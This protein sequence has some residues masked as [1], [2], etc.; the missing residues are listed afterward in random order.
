MS[1]LSNMRTGSAG[2][3]LA[4][5]ASSAVTTGMFII[6]MLWHFFAKSVYFEMLTDQYIIT[7]YVV[8]AWACLGFLMCLIAGI[9]FD[10][11]PLIHGSEPFHENAMRQFLVMNFVGQTVIF[12]STFMPTPERIIEFSTVGIAFLSLGV[13]LL[14]GPGRRLFNESSMKSKQ[15]E[16]GL[17]SLIVG[18]VLPLLGAATL[19][20]WM[21]RDTDGMLELGRSILVMFYLLVA[22]VMMISHFNR[23]LNWKIIEPEGLPLRMGAFL[24]LAVLHIL[25]AFLEGREEAGAGLLLTQMKDYT[26]GSTMLV[27]FLICNPLGISKKALL[28]GG[29]AHS[30]P[31]FLALWMLPFASFHAF[32]SISYTDRPGTPGYATFLCTSA[33]LIIWGYAWY[34]H[35]DHLHIN[36]HKRKVNL[37]LLVSFLV[38]FASI[39][40]LYYKNF[41][42]NTDTY[43]EQVMWIS[44][45]IIGALIMA[46]NFVRMTLLTFNTWHRIPM[47]YG[48]YIQ[49]QS[50][51]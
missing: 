3:Y 5:Y 43:I 8:M 29:M 47:F 51:D 7:V 39:Q 50:M 22:L 12:I 38:G 21:F 30:R 23:R 28:N 4:L 34:L 24:L 31:I 41:T 2:S 45:I 49:N 18:M 44:S 37:P 19:T 16:V 6:A 13:F 15:D 35:E 48:R 32:N 26:L 27:A 17:A 9:G 10:I 42:G 36:I 46:F 33:I 40:V 1:T 11:L 14:G 20:C 25:F